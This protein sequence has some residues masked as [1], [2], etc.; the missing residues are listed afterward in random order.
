MSTRRKHN[1]PFLP[2]LARA[3]SDH[4]IHLKNM[5]FIIIVENFPIVLHLNAMGK[6]VTNKFEKYHAL[7]RRLAIRQGPYENYLA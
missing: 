7:P 1:D 4:S 2:D 5:N 6:W 3:K